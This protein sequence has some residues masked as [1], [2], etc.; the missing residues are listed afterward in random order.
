MVQGLWLRFTACLAPQECASV[1]WT[2][3][4]ATE[5]IQTFGFSMSYQ[6]VYTHS[7]SHSCPGKIQRS[8]V[9]PGEL[10]APDIA[11]HIQCCLEPPICLPVSFFNP[12]TKV[13][14]SP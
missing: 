11:L 5:H 7:G 14:F 12:P 13:A 9:E 10:C 4:C 2:I 8:D 1:S 3:Y 6:M